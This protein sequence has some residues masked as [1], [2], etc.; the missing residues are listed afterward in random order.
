MPPMSRLGWISGNRYQML[1]VVLSKKLRKRNPCPF[2]DKSF[3]LQFRIIHPVV[4]TFPICLDKTAQRTQL[5][6]P[7]N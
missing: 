7:A 6:S 5:H 4:H 1:V 2:E 3:D